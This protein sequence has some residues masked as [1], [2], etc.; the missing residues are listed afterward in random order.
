MS[1]TLDNITNGLLEVMMELTGE[2]SPFPAF[3]DAVK[4]SGMNTKEFV[5]AFCVEYLKNAPE[6]IRNVFIE[7]VRKNIKAA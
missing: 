1:M 4:N 5:D 2:N 3:R 6:E 7:E